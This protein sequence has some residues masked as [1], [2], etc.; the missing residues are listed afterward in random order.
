MYRMYALIICVA[1][2]MIAQPVW[3]EPA[4]RESIL[5]LLDASGSGELGLDLADEIIPELKAMLPD[6]P[7]RFWIE[8]RAE[9]AADSLVEQLIP[10]YQKYLTAKDVDAI[11][12][13]Y[14]TP[15]GKKLLEAQ[16]L[17]TEETFRLSEKWG[18]HVVEQVILKYQREVQAG[19]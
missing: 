3:A 6:A 13:F 11:A 10:V 4:S 15:A 2:S 18:E 14:T 5:K 16:P 1:I 9:I 12:A 8:V 17:I 19:P 7:S